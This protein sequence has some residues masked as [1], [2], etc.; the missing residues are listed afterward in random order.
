M[1]T[2]IYGVIRNSVKLFKVAQNL[3]HFSDNSDR[4]GI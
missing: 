1:E 3:M 2:C 4:P